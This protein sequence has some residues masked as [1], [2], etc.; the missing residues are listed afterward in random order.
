MPAA[1][2]DQC[3]INLAAQPRKG[4]PGK[5]SQPDTGAVRIQLE[6]EAVHGKHVPAL[7]RQPLWGRRFLEPEAQWNRGGIVGIAAHLA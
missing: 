3:A 4:G 6:Y 2:D 5:R 7:Q 1:A